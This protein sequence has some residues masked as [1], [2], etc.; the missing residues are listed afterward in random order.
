MGVFDGKLNI[1][2]IY[3]C[4][5]TER[6]VP[7]STRIDVAILTEDNR[8]AEYELGTRKLEMTPGVQATYH[9]LMA[10]WQLTPRS[11]VY[12]HENIKKNEPV[13]ML[14]KAMSQQFKIMQRTVTTDGMIRRL[15]HIHA[16]F[17]NRKSR[18]QGK[19]IMK[20][21]GNRLY[22]QKVWRKV[23]KTSLCPWITKEY[24]AYLDSRGY[25]EIKRRKQL[26]RLGMYYIS[27]TNI[28]SAYDRKCPSYERRKCTRDARDAA[29]AE[30]KQA[31]L[32]ASV[33]MDRG[34]PDESAYGLF[35]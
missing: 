15:C 32:D 24:D 27:E 30:A 4:S 11:K 6:A 3:F 14:F 31:E 19:Y 9:S 22:L 28:K 13:R 33:V 2:Y 25:M 21:E 29:R 1:K 23:V 34:E 10:D 18:R 8:Y 26:L 20:R 17:I 7:R 12:F 16:N 5:Y 35:S